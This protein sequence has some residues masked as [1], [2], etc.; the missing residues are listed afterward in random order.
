MSGYTMPYLGY[1]NSLNYTMY[2]DI[3]MNSYKY[4][5]YLFGV[6]YDEYNK[7]K[8]YI[9]AIPGKKSE[10]PDKGTTGFT[11]YQTCDNRSTSL[12]YWLCFIDSKARK[13]EK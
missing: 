10:Q 6:Q 11:T 3:A 8:N 13:I 9:Y 2:S 1:V 5:H 4:R 7:R 12:G